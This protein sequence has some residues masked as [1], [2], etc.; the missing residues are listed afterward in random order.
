MECG[1]VATISVACGSRG[2][3]QWSYSLATPD[4]GVGKLIHAG[5]RRGEIVRR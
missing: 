3:L 2:L 4:S 1:G 5:E